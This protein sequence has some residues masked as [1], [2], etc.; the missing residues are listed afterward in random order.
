MVPLWA[1]R[2]R[3][4]RGGAA[5]SPGWSER[6]GRIP[7]RGGNRTRDRE[8]TIRPPGHAR[9]KGRGSPKSAPTREE[10]AP[11]LP[12]PSCAPSVGSHLRHSSSELA[13]SIAPFFLQHTRLPWD[14]RLAWVPGPGPRRGRT[15]PAQALRAGR[16]PRRRCLQAAAV[17]LAARHLEGRGRRCP[18]WLP[19]SG[20]QRPALPNFRVTHFLDV[21]KTFSS[22]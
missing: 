9:F 17:E 5:R 16:G 8:E 20:L 18:R 22:L 4:P 1:P 15:A 14:L 13:V 6:P 19:P 7:R 10:Q 3:A 2:L 12:T 11:A 21:T